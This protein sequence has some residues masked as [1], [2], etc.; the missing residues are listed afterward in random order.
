MKVKAECV[1]CGATRMIEAGE[2]V[3]GDVP[4]CETC[5][6]PMVA[7]EAVGEGKERHG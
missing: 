6:M 2:V 7:V 3:P 4:M 5:Y 1:Q